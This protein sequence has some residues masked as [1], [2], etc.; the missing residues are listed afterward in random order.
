M[1][2]QAVWQTGPFRTA[3]FAALLVVGYVLSHAPFMRLLTEFNVTLASHPWLSN[4]V[5]LFYMPVEEYLIDHTMLDGPLLA[6]A[7][8]WQMGDSFRTDRYYRTEPFWRDGLEQSREKKRDD[9]D[10]VSEWLEAKILR[11]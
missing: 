7:D 2:R 11:Y 3:I 5:I 4:A 1:S 8:L 10:S 9:A 6:W